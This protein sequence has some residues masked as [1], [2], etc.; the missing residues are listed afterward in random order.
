M[1]GAL[2]A[3]GVS[4]IGNSEKGSVFVG[5]PT[6]LDDDGTTIELYKSDVKWTTTFGFEASA[7]GEGSTALGIGTKAAGK[8]STALGISANAT[9]NNSVSIGSG[10]EANTEHSTAIGYNAHANHRLS[11]A[12]G[13][14]SSTNADNQVSF[15]SWDVYNEEWVNNYNL[16][17]IDN[18]E[19]LG[20]LKVGYED[21]NMTI[22]GEGKVQS[23]SLTDGTAT[24][25]GGGLTNL[26]NINGVSVAG[27]SASTGL[28]V[29]D[30]AIIGK[31]D[32]PFSS[33]GFSVS[34]TGALTAASINGAAVTATKFNGVTLGTDGKVNGAAITS[35]SFNSVTLEKDASSHYKVGGV[36]VTQMQTDVAG[37]A[38]KATTLAGYGITDVYT[39]DAADAAITAATDDMATKT[40]VTADISTVKTELEMAYKDADTALS[41]RTDKL[42]TATTGMTY[43]G[44]A[45]AEMTTFAGGITAANLTVGSNFGVTA[46]GALTAKTV[47]GV[48]ISNSSG[49]ATFNGVAIKKDGSAVTVGGID[50][51]ALSKGD[52]VTDN[53]KAIEHAGTVG[54]SDS[55]TTIEKNTKIAESGIT[56]NA[57]TA[58]GTVT[59]AEFVEGSQKLSDKYAAKAALDDYTTTADMN[60]KFADYATTAA[61]DTKLGDYAKSDGVYSK[62]DADAAFAKADGS[63]LQTADVS[64][65]KNA[66]GVDTLTESVTTNAGNITAL[67]GKVNTTEGKVSTLETTV[68]DSSTGLVKR[69]DDLETATTGMTYASGTTT[70]AGGVTAASLTVGSNFGVTAD[71]ALTAKT[72]NGVSISNSSGTATFNGVAIKKDGSAVTVGGIDLTALS[73]GDVVTDNT[74]GISRSDGAPYTTTIEENTKIS[75]SGIVVTGTVEATTLKEGGQELSARYAGISEAYTAEKA[76]LKADK[77]DVDTL[78]TTVG[79]AATGLVKDMGDLQTATSALQAATTGMS[80]DS[81]TASTSFSGN[82]VIGNV[83]NKTHTQITDSAIIFG[84]GAEKQVTV[85]A[86]GIHVGAKAMNGISTFADAGGTHIDHTSL[87]TDTVTAGNLNVN[88]A[89]ISGN[90]TDGLSVGGVNIKELQDR[91]TTIENNGGGSG[92]GGTGT[93]NTDTVGIKR[94]DVSGDGVNDT[95]TI[96]GA[97]SFTDTGMKTTNLTA[98]TAAIGGVD[99]A[100]NGVVTSVNSINGVA[101]SSDGKIGGVTLSGG[102]VNGA[103]ITST[104]FNGV[105]VKALKNKVDGLGTGGSGSGGTGGSGGANTSGITKPDGD[106]TVIEGNTNISGDGIETNKVTASDQIIVAD[107]KDNQ[108]TI[109]E[110]GIKVAAGKTNEVTINDNGI[111]VGKNSSVMNDTEGFITDK[112]LYI[113]VDSSSDTSTAKFSV[114]KG[115]GTM[116]SKVG[117]YSFTNG[118]NGAVFSKNGDTAYGTGS[119]LDTAIQ[120][121]KVTTGQLNADEL[122]V[123]GN[124]VTVSGGT[125]NQTDAIDNQL[126]ATK[127]GYDYTNGFTTTETQGTTQ[128]ASQTS[129]DGKEKLE[130]VNNTFASGTSI[131]TTKT[132]TDSSDKTTVKESSFATNASGMSLN[133]SHKVTDKDGNVTK[134]TSGTTTMTGGSLTVSQTTVTTKDGKEE[135]KIS[136]TKID[137]GEITLERENGTIRVGDA[138]EGMQGQVQE[139]GN[140]VNEMGVE[141]KEVGALSAALAGLHP[142][143]QNANSRA[144]FAMAMG[145]YE[146]KQALAVGGFY[147]PDKRTMLSIGASTTSSKH[148]MNMGIS[149]ALDR[150]PEEE[151]KVQEAA[152]ADPETL[153]KVLERLAALEQD[154]QRLQADNKKR[155]I[156]YEKLAADYTQLKEK[157]TEKTA[158]KQQSETKMEEAAPAEADS[159]S[160]E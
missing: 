66:L 92:S 34:H 61:V 123:G 2:N 54:S 46:D 156:A 49:T 31:T 70:F 82:V 139:I 135:T 90:A 130:T 131:T 62:T 52:V 19:M 106:N 32:M 78:K 155:D 112:G 13:S 33:T 60:T 8:G 97:T 102:K 94:T 51:T 159:S 79:D 80:Y 76:A 87:V 25:S 105:D 119:Q 91:V 10:S 48:A 38:D 115:N 81:G 114:D 27:T 9:G 101:F 14:N 93:P 68:G 75:S 151:R 64:S 141:I 67:T 58:S 107:G 55:V 28:T 128:S 71:G 85:D 140:K 126:T 53:T 150:L 74:K 111:H 84:Q 133:T 47:N 40:Q 148:M 134:D 77:T 153:N 158:E 88:G 157:Y 83:G 100:A 69:T 143:P 57:I 22:I 7:T 117:S 124:K 86:S 113:G 6:M 1:A 56:T 149:I 35:N 144:D 59:A 154:N 108:T 120:G 122:W 16:V 5:L 44:T 43:S 36:D 121:N 95:T 109:G 132:S 20:D 18:L 65:W 72:V 42:E 145:S 137:S 89:A 17:G 96:E 29:G 11:V 4:F 146:G 15:G 129:A 103:E 152:A 147:R 45:G 116:T 104:S 30:N 39:I 21:D 142:Q 63:N 127:D 138:I 73:K 37:K 50:L 41:D 3:G 118:S 26:K 110:D 12:I 125:V 160:E 24:L 98:A 136:S 23:V 99:F